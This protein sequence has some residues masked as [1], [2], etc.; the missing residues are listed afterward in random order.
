RQE[1]GI[2]DASSELQQIF[3][4]IGKTVNV[5]MSR[6]RQSGGV[7]MKIRLTAVPL[8][9]DSV[10][11]GVGSYITERGAT[12]PWFQW[13]M[14]AG[15]RI[16][17]R[18]YELEPGH[19]EVSRTGNMIMKRGKKGWRVPPEFAGSPSNNFITRATDSILPELGNYIQKIVKSAL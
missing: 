15:D 7:N 13:L 10:I 5:T 6:G 12:I 2:V 9:I 17:V 4:A 18:D 16:I 3:Q 8:N 19:V 11:A 14:S 1:M